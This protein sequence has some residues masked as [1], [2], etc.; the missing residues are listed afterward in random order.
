MALVCLSHFILGI[1]YS[2]NGLLQPGWTTILTSVASPAFVTISGLIFSYLLSAESSHSPKARRRMVERALLL[3]I[4]VHVL[5]RMPHW[6]S[7]EPLSQTIRVIEI[8]DTVA[9]AMLVNLYLVRVRWAP[10]LILAASLFAVGWIANLLWQPTATP[11]V[12]LKDLLVRASWDDRSVLHGFA[13]VPWTAIH[14]AATVL[15]ERLRSAEASGHYRRY[16]V[17]LVALGVVS[18][19]TAAVCKL[20]EVL[21]RAQGVLDRATP[22]GENISILVSPF[23]KYPPTPAY[24]A[25]C[26]G[27][28]LILIAAVF[29]VVERG[30]LTWG[31]SQAA[32]LGQASLG[33]WVTQ[34]WIYWGIVRSM[35]TPP[36]PLLPLYGAVSLVAVALGAHQWTRLGLNRR[37][38]VPFLWSRAD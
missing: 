34:A 25:F 12:V 36:M 6:L 5:V 15:G 22:W 37:L 7:G 2:T 21:A 28:G 31:V 14:L 11:L 19:G 26:G 38:I 35:P 1:S 33:A 29:L 10:R 23:G 3:L 9:V 17:Q 8:T 16:V 24:V 4:P 18:M 13:F 20:L 32:M 30:W 27:G